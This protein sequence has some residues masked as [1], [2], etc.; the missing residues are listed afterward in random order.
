MELNEVMRKYKAAV[1][2]LSVDQITLQDQ[3]AQLMTLEH[4]KSTLKEQVRPV[5]GAYHLAPWH[6]IVSFLFILF[7]YLFIFERLNP[8]VA[9]LSARLECLEIDTKSVHTQKRME[10]KV[11]ELE[12]RVELEQTSKS[13]LEVNNVVIEQTAVT[14]SRHHF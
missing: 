8:Q 4:E 10:L 14:C 9:E 12:S 3:T 11:K 7:I 13:R 6:I 2:Q 1:A 5:L